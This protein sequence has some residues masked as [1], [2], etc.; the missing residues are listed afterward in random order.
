MTTNG[1]MHRD[2]LAWSSEVE[3]WEADLRAWR[4]ECE[5]AQT[6]IN[7]YMMALT[8][9]EERV[10]RHARAIQI[11]GQ[12]AA[13]HEHV[14]KLQ[15]QGCPGRCIVPTSAQHDREAIGHAEMRLAHEQIKRK[16]HAIMAEYNRLLR[17]LANYTVQEPRQ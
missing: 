1:T 4:L 5:A 9:H 6:A 11:D 16:H 7:G 12:Q 2:H 14:L 13:A 15:E 3:M 10:E 17:R 8:E